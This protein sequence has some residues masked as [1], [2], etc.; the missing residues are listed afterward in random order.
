MSN[1]PS[2][3]FCSFC[4][5]RAFA[6][7][8]AG[9]L[10]MWA[11]LVS[12]IVFTACTF[13]YTQQLYV[14]FSKM[15]DLLQRNENHQNKTVMVTNIP[16]E[17]RSEI[18]LTRFLT[19]IYGS[20]VVKVQIIPRVEKLDKL[21]KLW[22]KYQK[23]L[24]QCE[25]RLIESPRQQRPAHRLKLF[26]YAGD[27]VDSIEYYMEKLRLVKSEIEETKRFEYQRTRTA[28]VTFDSI[29]TAMQC[30]Q[31]LHYNDPR[32]MVFDLAPAPND[33]NWKV[34]LRK[35]HVWWFRSVLIWI[36]VGCLF[37]FWSAPISYIASLDVMGELSRLDGSLRFL[38]NFQGVFSSLILVIFYGVLPYLLGWLLDLQ[39][40]NLHSERDRAITRI[41]WLFLFLNFFLVSV[42]QDILDSLNFDSFL[43]FALALGSNMPSQVYFFLNYL[44]LQGMAIYPFFWLLRFDEFVWVKLKYL[45]AKTQL[46][47]SKAELQPMQFNYPLLFSR[48]VFI[49]LCLSVC[50]NF[51]F[52][53]AKSSL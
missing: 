29:R 43:E 16:H 53:S 15:N 30:S 4:L 11:H 31:T 5:F 19:E 32:T 2:G 25:Q 12:V 17:Y 35:K 44:I 18:E 33:L 36:L 14:V 21:W 3:A 45:F 40:F 8:Y 49:S 46:D 7:D 41:Y 50:A 38:K 27:R 9:S 42:S 22:N 24:Q 1:I 23:N 39:G 13:F 51:C 28:F 48:F 6:E 37:L 26:G 20:K 34:L 10:R 52:F 47:R